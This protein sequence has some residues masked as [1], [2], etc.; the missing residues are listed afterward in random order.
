[1]ED[2]GKLYDMNIKR[3]WNWKDKLKKNMV[4]KTQR[5]FNEEKEF[6]TWEMFR[7]YKI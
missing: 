7:V 1:M 4:E 3:K 5:D 6:E 2:N